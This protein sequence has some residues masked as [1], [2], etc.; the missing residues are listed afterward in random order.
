MIIAGIDNGLSGAMI[1][2]DETGR[3]IDRHVTPTVEAKTGKG[4]REYDIPSIVFNLKVIAAYQGEKMVY[5]ERAQGM[6][7]QGLSSTFKIGFGYGV[8]QG[9]LT[10]LG[11]PYEI[12]DPRRWQ[13]EM[14]KDV[15]SKDTKQASAMVARRL[16]P[17]IDW[18]ENDRCRKP[19]DGLTDAYCIAEYGRRSRIHK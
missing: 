14:F 12:V 13:G 3:V 5:L 7:R 1:V 15:N 8:W 2:L 11:I 9:I 10:A 6:P 17:D 16:A 19:H 4:K 18:R